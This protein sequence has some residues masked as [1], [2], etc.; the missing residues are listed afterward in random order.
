MNLNI[1]EAKLVMEG[2]FTKPINQENNNESNDVVQEDN[3]WMPIMSYH[4]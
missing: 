2:I 4:W 1:V 3:S